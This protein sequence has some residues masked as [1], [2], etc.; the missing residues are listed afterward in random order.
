VIDL[1]QQLE[2]FART[3]GA[4]YPFEDW[5]LVIG[6]G[7]AGDRLLRLA[8]DPTCVNRDG[9]LGLL[10]VYAGQLIREGGNQ[11]NRD[12]LAELQAVIDRAQTI[13]RDD[14]RA[15]ATRAAAAL[16]GHGPDPRPDASRSDY[17]FWFGGGWRDP[18]R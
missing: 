18:A 2:A 7:V 11:R 15:W 6:G 13:D 16:A 12:R 5:D 9:V 3:P 8:T 10:Y 17:E 1:D 4:L 14:L